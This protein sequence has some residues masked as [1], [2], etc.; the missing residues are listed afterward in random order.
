MQIECEKKKIKTHLG[1]G[2]NN[3]ETLLNLKKRMRRDRQRDI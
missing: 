1:W 2:V 3:I